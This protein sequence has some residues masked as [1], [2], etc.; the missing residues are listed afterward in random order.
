M[1]RIRRLRF[2]GVVPLVEVLCIIRR[3]PY[4]PSRSGRG[5]TRTVSDPEHLRIINEAWLHG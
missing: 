2:Q 1:D 3:E 5:I 4:E